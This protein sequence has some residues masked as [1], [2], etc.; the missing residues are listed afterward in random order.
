MLVAIRYVNI[1]TTEITIPYFYTIND[2][3][4][5]IPALINNIGLRKN[6]I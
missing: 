1:F 2:T 6:C 4:L 3:R 5:K